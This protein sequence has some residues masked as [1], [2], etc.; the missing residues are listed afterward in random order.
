VTSLVIL[1]RW[2]LGASFFIPR[3]RSAGEAVLPASINGSANRRSPVRKNRLQGY[4]S[5]VLET[6]R[7]RRLLGREDRVLVA[8]SAGPDSTALLA[9]LAALRDA[10]EVAAVAAVHVDHGLRPAGEDAACAE[11]NCARLRIPFESVK[12]TVGSGNVQAAARRVRYAALR[13][14]AKRSGATRIATGH[15]R[16]DQAE[17]VLLRLLRGA[18]ARGLAGIPARRGPI[19]RPLLD[20]SR[21]EGLRYLESVGLSWRED[22]TNATPRFARNRLRL[23]VWPALVSLAPA[24]ERALSRTADLSRAD[25]RALARRARELVPHGVAVPLDAL[26]AEPVAVRRRVV[27]R[28]WRNATGSAGSL[29]MKHVEAVLSVAGRKRPGWVVLPNG[30]EARSRYGLLELGAALAPPSPP[31]HVEVPHPGRYRL[32]GSDRS[33][34]I[35]VRDPAA[36]RWPLSLR[37][38]RPGDRFR[39]EGGRGSKK[40]KSWLIDRKIPREERDALLVLA[41]G[42]RVVAVPELSVVAAGLGPSG[43]DLTVRVHA[44]P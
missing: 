36:L 12:V 42:D 7:R 38:R 20:S 35:A 19:V 23:L 3:I 39:P 5:A 22:P 11:A 25:E 8:L 4:P 40:L 33:V 10:G 17:T 27:R 41:E 28:L 37:A 15:T 30:L 13:A 26:R 21:A 18:G 9:A 2:N 24:L 6:I 14:A 34:D 1:A 16:T 32:P 29:E 43:A 31:V 44:R